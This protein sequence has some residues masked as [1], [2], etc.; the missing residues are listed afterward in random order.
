MLLNGTQQWEAKDG[1]MIVPTLNNVN[2]PS[3]RMKNIYP[4][5]V[6]TPGTGTWSTITAGPVWNVSGYNAT[7]LGPGPTGNNINGTISPVATLVPLQSV[8]LQHISNFNTGGAYFTGLSPT[9]TL[10]VNAI[11]YIE[12]FPKPED[13]NLVVLANPSPPYNAAAMSL[14]TEFMRGM[15]VGCKVGDNADGD[16]FFEAV[17]SVADFLAPALGL[18]GAIHPALAVA[19]PAFAT[20]ASSW[21][22]QKLIER[23]PGGVQAQP[24]AAV[25]RIAGVPNGPPPAYK[26]RPQPKPAAPKAAQ[27]KVKRPV[28]FQ[29]AVWKKLTEQQKRHYASDAVY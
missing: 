24:A 9:T 3:E 25:R 1:C 11:Y 16:W 17:K 23:N 4:V 29:K 14:Y 22:S 2:I 12:R 20:A 13:A 27:S 26:P 21:A 15:P 28:G 18:A 6:S 10:T 8:N 19:A 5:S 7:G